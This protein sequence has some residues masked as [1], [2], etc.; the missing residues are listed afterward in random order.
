MARAKSP[1][2]RFMNSWAGRL[3]LAEAMALTVNALLRRRPPATRS[4][5]Q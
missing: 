4:R 2:L 3:L 1:F 5:L